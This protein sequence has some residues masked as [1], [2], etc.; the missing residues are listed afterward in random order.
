MDVSFTL[1]NSLL[2]PKNENFGLVAHVQWGDHGPW[3]IQLYYVYY[4][5][6][7]LLLF[8]P[9]ILM[10]PRTMGFNTNSIWKSTHSTS[11]RVPPLE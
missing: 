2:K 10:Y 3:P 5:S 8:N 11:L 9:S 1:Y 7:H 4:I 6:S